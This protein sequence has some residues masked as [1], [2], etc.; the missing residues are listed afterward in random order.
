LFAWNGPANAHSPFVSDEEIL[1][2]ELLEEE[3]E[4][5]GHESAGVCAAN[6]QAGKRITAETAL[7]L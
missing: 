4:A 7:D 5:R 6:R 2:G 1:P 3:P